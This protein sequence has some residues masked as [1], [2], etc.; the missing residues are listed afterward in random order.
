MER[1]YPKA[2]REL[3]SVE[4]IRIQAARLRSE[5]RYLEDRCTSMTRSYGE[6]MGGSG[7]I[8]PELWDRLAD[9][10]ELLALQERILTDRELEVSR[11][12]DL[13]PRARWRMVL[14]CLYLEGMDLHDVATAM[15]R[16]TGRP[17]TMNQIYRLH[18]AALKAM[19]ELQEAF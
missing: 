19:E 15:S 11:R 1:K 10:K 3:E 13:L 9:R 17:F 8:R 4:E 14:R 18:S 12:I 2:R 16:A 5:I 6:H 7:Q